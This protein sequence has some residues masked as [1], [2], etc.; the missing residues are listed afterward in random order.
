MD[1]TTSSLHQ[2]KSENANH[3]NDTVVIDPVIN[4]RK[5]A[6]ERP[7]IMAC[8]LGSSTRRLRLY[9]DQGATSLF[10]LFLQISG[11]GTRQG[12]DRH[13]PSKVGVTLGGYLPVSHIWE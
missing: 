5:E 6:Q 4:N 1:S 3:E 11:A 7:N 13:M 8:H 12:G 10:S 2:L 9:T